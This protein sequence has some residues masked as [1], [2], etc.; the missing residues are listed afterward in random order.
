MRTSGAKSNSTFEEFNKFE[1][2]K[3]LD[4]LSRFLDEKAVTDGQRKLF[5]Y[6]LDSFESKIENWYPPERAG[7]VPVLPFL[8]LPVFLCLEGGAKTETSLKI[9]SACTLLYLGFDVFDD[10][11]DG[12]C[13]ANSDDF[14]PAEMNLAAA[15]FLCCLPQVLLSEIPST[16]STL[17]LLQKTAAE[18]MLRMSAGQQRDLRASAEKNLS[19]E[20]VIETVRLK[21]GAEIEMFARMAASAAGFSERKT[22]AFA[23]YG[24]N[25]GI[26]G[27]IV[28]DCFDFF[29]DPEC[30]D[31]KNGARTL[32]VVCYQTGIKTDP[33][34]TRQF[35]R[36]LESARKSEAARASLRELVRNAEI[37]P[38]CAFL[39]EKFCRRAEQAL[40]RADFEN[41]FAEKGLRALIEDVSLLEN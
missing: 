15:A 30:R 2:L 21:S 20:A 32:P 10:V 34:R 36:L 23:E 37:L 18:H 11:A 8:H 7:D 40:E 22:E 9:A 16:P 1:T 13:P 26:A 35:S 12:D 41:A 6:A 38:F 19:I 24:L 28:S 29:Q 33:K 14:T 25:L 17:L 5:R 27:Q 4:F 3:V 31:L 39:I